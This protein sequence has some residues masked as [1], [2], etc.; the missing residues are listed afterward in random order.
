MHIEDVIGKLIKPQERSLN[1]KQ[2]QRF[3]EEMLK[4]E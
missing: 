1:R 4:N 3:A 2:L